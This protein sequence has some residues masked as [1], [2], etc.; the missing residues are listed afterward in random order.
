MQFLLD[1]ESTIR[2]S[3]F[4]GVLVLMATA[5]ALAPKKKR[6]MPR[7]TRWLTNFGIVVVDS[8]VLRLLMPVLAVG[9]A[10]WA[11]KNNT[12]LLNLVSLPQ[13]LEIVLAVVILDMLIYAQHVAS[14]KIP[15]LWKFHKVHHADRD[16]DVTT[17]A[18]FHPFEIIFSMLYKLLCVVLLG[19]AVVA[20]ILFEVMLNASAMFNH[21]NLSLPKKVDG[22]MRKLVVTPD[23]HRVHHSIIHKETDSNYGFFLS[24]WDQIFGTYIPQPREGHDGMTIGLAEVQSHKPNTLWWCLFAPFIAQEK[25]PVGSDL[26]DNQ[27]KQGSQNA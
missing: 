15:L 9:A 13:W 7:L 11:I 4:L 16:I 2:L 17:G 25:I 14:H 8:I 21:A 19:P 23:F 18:R 10:A 6:T 12:G 26:E 5:E 1:H 27:E 24:V 3:V 22:L 20:V